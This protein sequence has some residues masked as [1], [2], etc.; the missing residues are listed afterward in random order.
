MLKCRT[1]SLTGI[2]RVTKKR[3]VRNTCIKLIIC[4]KTNYENLCTSYSYSNLIVCCRT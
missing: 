1:V 4:R 3:V 2:E